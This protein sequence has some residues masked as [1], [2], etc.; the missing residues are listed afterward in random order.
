VGIKPVTFQLVGSNPVYLKN[1]RTRKTENKF[2]VF[3][4]G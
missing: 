1:N 2:D 4:S 3:D